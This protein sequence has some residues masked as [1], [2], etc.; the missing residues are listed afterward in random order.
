MLEKLTWSLLGKYATAKDSEFRG[1]GVSF[2]GWHSS[3]F[4]WLSIVFSSRSFLEI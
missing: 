1:H 3:Q 4:S 2:G